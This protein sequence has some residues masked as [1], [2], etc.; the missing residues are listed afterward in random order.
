MASASVVLTSDTSGSVTVTVPSGTALGTTTL[1]L[2][3]SGGTIQTS[4]AGF[5]T[6]G[7]AYAS[8]TSAL[9]TGSS[10]VFSSGN[11]GVGTSSPSNL[12]TLNTTGSDTMPALGANGGKLGIFSGSLGYGLVVGVPS[13]GTATLQSQYING[14][15]SALDMSLQPLGGNLLVGSASNPGVA[16]LAVTSTV[17]GQSEILKLS[18]STG[19]V[20]GKQILITQ[21]ISDTTSRYLTCETNNGNTAKLY[22]YSNGNVVNANNSYGALSDAKLKENIVDASPKLTGLMQ[23]KVRNYNLIG[24]TTKQIGVVAQELETV[25]PSMI[26]ISPDIDKNGN[27][28]GTTTK[29]VKYSVFVPMLIKSVQELST[30]ITAQQS[31][32]QSLTER[33]TALEGART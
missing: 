6:N 7:V 23:V 5:T 20:Y 27:D 14:T 25:F 26:D 2:P 8:S 12:L 1:T 9:A 18:A 24:D 29:S 22:I 15:A 17:N 28:L 33:I 30:L 19:D 16:R 32:I 4:G 13:S 11:L 31:T 10:L 3:T 21:N